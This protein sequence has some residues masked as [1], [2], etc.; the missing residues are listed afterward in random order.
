MNILF[1]HPN[2][3]KRAYNQ[4]CAICKYTPHTPYLLYGEPDVSAM[5]LADNVKRFCASYKKVFRFRKIPYIYKF[6]RRVIRRYCKEWDIDLIHAFNMPD[7]VAVAAI[8]TK[9]VPV[10]FDVRD[11]VTSF[12]KKLLAKRVLPDKFLKVHPIY[13]LTSDSVSLYVSNMEKKAI[14]ESTARVFST[15]CMLEYSRDRY[16]IDDNNIVFYNYALD[17]E[18]PGKKEKKYSSYDGEIHT[19]F[20]GNISIH[21]EYRNFLPLFKKLANKK[22][23]VH[24]HVVTKDKASLLACK[25]VAEDN[26]YLHFY[27][28]MPVTKILRELSKC[29]FGLLPFSTKVEKKYFDLILPNKLFD[30]LSAGL[31]VAST[32]IQC[33]KRFL[34]I[35]EVGF[36]Y[37]NEEDL[38]AKLLENMG[39]F[40]VKPEK[41]L[42]GSNIKKLTKLYEN[43]AG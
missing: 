35:N 38:V 42:I 6:F 13:K 34:E 20:T 27:P 40:T 32:D 8:E 5:N 26:R 22:I 31:P 19:G 41:F 7:D 1:V 23:H 12:S 37:E 25:K 28:P 43:I 18:S 15:E 30:Y 3:C 10:I 33:V 36:I 21:D 39:K 4:I 14:E 11:M 16:N 17:D 2:L 9:T 29:D 24:M